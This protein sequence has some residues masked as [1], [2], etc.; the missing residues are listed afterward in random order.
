MLTVPSCLFDCR[1]GLLTLRPR[2]VLL[3][4]WYWHSLEACNVVHSLLYYCVVHCLT[5][6]FN[7]AVHFSCWVGASFIFLD[8]LKAFTSV[9][10]LQ[11][12]L[13]LVAIYPRVMYLSRYLS[14][15]LVLYTDTVR[16]RNL[17]R[18]LLSRFE[19]AISNDYKAFL[20]ISLCS[21]H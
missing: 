5:S 12:Q 1:L 13:L 17:G 18:T 10:R 15:H 9:N 2:K 4:C 20:C 21:H 6:P 14:V 16:N 8:C 3:W 19:H 7:S 11:V